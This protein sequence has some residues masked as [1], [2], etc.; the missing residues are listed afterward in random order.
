M[1]Q[2]RACSRACP[3]L[4]AALRTHR[5]SQAFVDASLAIA[6][7]LVA[8]WS[9][10]IVLLILQ[11]CGPRSAFGEEIALS[12]Q[13]LPQ[14][15]GKG[16]ADPKRLSFAVDP[17]RLDEPVPYHTYSVRMN[18]ASELFLIPRQVLLDFFASGARRRQ[19]MKKE[20]FN[21]LSSLAA[22]RASWITPMVPSLQLPRCVTCIIPDASLLAARE[23]SYTGLVALQAEKIYHTRHE[24][25][26]GISPTKGMS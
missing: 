11:I 20:L 4:D 7:Q 15:S 9:F 8:S 13:Q 3:V 22:G 25:N 24:M 19:D 23:A 12:G 14:G 18:V 16:A 10:L 6:Q 21:R 17:K 26:R 1:R 2:R 5:S